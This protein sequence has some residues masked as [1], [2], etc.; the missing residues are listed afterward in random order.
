MRWAAAA[1]AAGLIAAAPVPGAT[2]V[3]ARFVA[4][5]VYVDLPLKSGGTLD[6]YTD[7]GGGSLILS[8]RA[9][10]RVGLAL[11]PID[12]PQV[13]AALGKDA[14]SASPP[15][16]AGA[17]PPLP[18]RLFVVARA[19]QMPT[20]PEQ[21][22]GFLGAKWFEGGIWTWD[23]PAH[24]LRREDAAWVAGRGLHETALGFLTSADGSRP[25][26]FARIEVG[27]DGQ[28]VP[29]LLD[30]GAETFLTPAAL[31]R[32]GDGGPALRATSMIEASLF[33]RLHARHPDWAYVP[34]AQV[35]TGSPM[36]LVPSVEIAGLRSGPVWMTR[37][38]DAAYRQ[39][40]SSMMDRPV[41]GSLGG[42]ALHE[43]TMTVDFVRARAYFGRA[44]SP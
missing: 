29:M 41:A 28:T 33:D 40:M 25:T 14:R 21:G 8:R 39:F 35:A 31:A 4:D 15:A 11:H 2:D 34:V 19:A 9:A 3:P 27:I 36:L 38:S 13:R 32:L 7:S 24:H 12:N 18:A 23:Y 22:D 17:L 37:R 20:W 30:T 44:T 43:L 6:L 1:L 16:L 42:N 26:N 10:T 5:R